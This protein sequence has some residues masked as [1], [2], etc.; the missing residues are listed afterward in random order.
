[1]NKINNDLERALVREA[2][3]YAPWPLALLL[4]LG[5]F[6]FCII[7]GL[8]EALYICIYINFVVLIISY[9]NLA[10]FGMS[11]YSLCKKQNILNTLAPLPITFLIGF[12]EGVLYDDGY[13]FAMFCG[14]G[15]SFVGYC[16]LRQIRMALKKL[17]S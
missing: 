10:I 2:L 14:I 8:I 12:F 1:M 5:V 9:I 7:T 11:L 6:I 16:A 15:G 17:Q 3:F 13:W 4:T